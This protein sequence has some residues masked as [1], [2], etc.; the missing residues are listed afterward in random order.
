MLRGKVCQG[1]NIKS[2][3]FFPVFLGC[4]ML[5]FLGILVY[6]YH[7]SKTANPVMLDETG[8][9]RSSASH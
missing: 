4:V 2:P 3:K 5:L 6:V 8:K 1:M 7:G 9:V